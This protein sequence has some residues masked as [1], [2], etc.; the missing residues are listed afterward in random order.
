MSHYKSNLRDIQFNLFEAYGVDEYLGKAPF[1]EIDH[2]TAM[3]MLREVDRLATEDFAESFVEADRTKLKLVDGNIELP[4]GVKK[5]LDALH[6]GGWHLVGVSQ[7][8]GGFGAPETLRWAAAEFFAGANGAISL[9]PIGGLMARVIEAVGTPEQIEKFAIPMV[10]QNWG[11]SMVLTEADAG[12]DVGAGITKAIHVEGDMWHIEGVKRFITSG[13]NDYYD[14][15]IHVVLARPVGAAPGTKGLSMFIVPK[16]LINEDGSLGERNGVVTTNLEDKMG[17]RGSTTVELSF[18][19]DK[20]AVGYLVGDVHDGIRQMFL[21]IEDARMSIGVKA[22]GTLST[23]YLNALEYAQERVQSS[24]LT[25]VRDKTAPRVTIIHHPAVRRMLMNQKVYAEGLRALSMYAAWLLDM[26]HL[27]PEEEQWAKLNDLMLPMVK[28]YSSEKAYELLAQSLQVFGGSGYTRDYPIEQYIRDAK[29]DTIYEGTTAIQGLDLFFRKIAR[30]QGATLMV[31]GQSILE[32]IKDGSEEMAVERELL[33]KAL[34]DVQ[35]HV[36]ALVGFS[37]AAM[38]DPPEIYK[39]GLHT[40]PLLE[41]L[42]EVVIGWLL[43]RHADVALEA[44]PGASE[45]DRAFYEGK[46]ASARYFARTVLPQAT[47]RRELAQT[48]DG[49]LMDLAVESF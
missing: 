20:P 42:A 48:E 44:L 16:Y 2:D 11:S 49:G 46:I 5:S 1:E 27:H 23:G 29:I 13:D 3:D 41:S 8:L 40:T 28:G 10:E 12:S 6:D 30:D 24:D 37:M 26:A 9:Y 32:T 18:G 22:A 21:V 36:G 25:Q 45:S 38:Q 4:D 39:T 7:A 33:G 14:N 19:V 47:L 34:E 15:I 31:L 17:I 35:N 43:I